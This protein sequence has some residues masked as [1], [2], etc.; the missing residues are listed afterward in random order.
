[1]DSSRPLSVKNLVKNYETVQ[2]VKGISFD[3]VPGEI[4]G[5]LGPNG[6]G[7]T[8]IISCIVTL[9][10]PTSGNVE[11]FGYDMSKN[12]KRAKSMIGIVPQELIHH[13]FLV[14]KKS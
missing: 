7:K 4:F 2:A 3:L 12:P 10:K 8:S 9:E 1:M 5:L 11:V 6:A 14:L 13:G